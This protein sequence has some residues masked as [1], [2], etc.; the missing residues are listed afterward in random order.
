MEAQHKSHLV[1]T[2]TTVLQHLAEIR[3]V[4]TEGKTPT[5]ARVTPLPQAQRER[6]LEILD[7]LAREVLDIVEAVVPEWQTTSETTG[8]LAATRM[9]AN[10]LLGTI[11]E[12]LED[13]GPE[14]ISKR[15]GR[16]KDADADTIRRRVETALESVREA[17]QVVR[18]KDS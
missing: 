3:Q 12:L 4:V 18:D 1:S 6:L 10:V 15:Y 9:W 17:M 8:G 7:E 11:E 13:I 16:L 2:Y 14:R 5:G